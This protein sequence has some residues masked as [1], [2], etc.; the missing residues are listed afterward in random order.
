MFNRIVIEADTSDVSRSLFRLLVDG[1]L[2]AEGL[3]G[4]QVRLLIGQVLNRITP[5][6]QRTRTAISRE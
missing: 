5:R 1:H 2:I 3:T 6:R 4:A